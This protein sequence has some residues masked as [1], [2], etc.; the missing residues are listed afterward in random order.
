[1]GS[2]H[3][4]WI[5]IIICFTEIRRLMMKAIL[6]ILLATLWAIG[7][8]IIHILRVNDKLPIHEYDDVTIEVIWT[9]W[10][11]ITSFLIAFL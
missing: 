11:L 4:Y 10:A 7:F 6:C 2:D 1:M 3:A 8:I 9:F 5:R